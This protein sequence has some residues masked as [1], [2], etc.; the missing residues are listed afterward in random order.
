MIEAFLSVSR[1]SNPTRKLID[2]DGFMWKAIRPF[3]NALFDEATPDSLNRVLT[4]VSPYVP[5]ETW[6]LN[7]RMVTR[8][9]AAPPTVPYT[10]EVG[11]AVVTILLQVA[12]ID[13]P[14]PHIPIGTWAL[15]KKLPSLPRGRTGRT[16][17]TS[18]P[19]VRRVQ[20]LGNIE[21]LK[22]Y[23]LLVWSD[24]YPPWGSDAMYSSIQED[25]SGIGMGC[26]RGDLIERLDHVL[27]ELDQGLEYLQQHSPGIDGRSVDFSKKRYGLFKGLLLRQ[28][29]E[30]L[31]VLTR[32]P[33]RIDRPFIFT[34]LSGCPQSPI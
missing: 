26:H 25:F 20:A 10:E 4:L 21:I 18:G 16:L 12:S 6:S 1:A 14:Q 23:F 24:W 2:W 27:G 7:R 5:L 3:V 9:A 15:L 13:F 11:Q 33:F 19:V 30:T 31:E 29:R 28:E 8:W 17:E 22:S 32:T 34:H